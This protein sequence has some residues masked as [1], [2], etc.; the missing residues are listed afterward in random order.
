MVLCLTRYMCPYPHSQI[1]FCGREGAETTE[2]QWEGKAK[3]Y[4]GALVVPPG[5]VFL[6]I[7][8]P[9]CKI[10]NQMQQ[11][12]QNRK[13][14]SY[15]CLPTPMPCVQV[16]WQL[17]AHSPFQTLSAQP[18][19]EP[20]PWTLQPPLGKALV[21]TQACSPRLLSL[22][23][24]TRVHVQGHLYL[25]APAEACALWDLG[26][27]TFRI[28]V[29]PGRIRL[30]ILRLWI[31]GAAEY[32]NDNNHTTKK[33]T[34]INSFLFIM[35]TDFTVLWF[36]TYNSTMRYILSSYFVDKESEAQRGSV[37]CPKSHN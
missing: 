34:I 33:T 9:G 15:V 13:P 7:S 1:S 8:T 30:V 10:W 31:L 23:L 3:L 19:V 36:S 25:Q 35:G 18:K 37:Y 16:L 29:G 14:S 20:W 17:L 5:I 24:D 6:L 32:N 28:W 21:H 11:P 22:Y 12:P 4:L 26:V 27:P 2:K